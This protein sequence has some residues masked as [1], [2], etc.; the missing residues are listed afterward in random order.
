LA[1][2]YLRNNSCLYVY[3]NGQHV[4]GQHA[5]TTRA[6][7]DFS[8][9]RQFSRFAAPEK[10]GTHCY[11]DRGKW[12]E[13]APIVEKLAYAHR[14][15]T[16]NFVVLPQLVVVLVSRFSCLRCCLLADR[17]RHGTAGMLQCRCMSSPIPVACA[18]CC[19]MG[20]QGL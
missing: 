12:R 8:P 9:Q 11:A 18:A 6:A 1:T 5:A 4:D 19:L 13:G 7:L 20:Q 17:L 10:K 14:V 15:V 16:A 3:L 2:T